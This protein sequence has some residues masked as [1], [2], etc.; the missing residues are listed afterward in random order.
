MVAIFIFDLLVTLKSTII[1]TKYKS[2]NI[3][4][5]C[6][7]MATTLYKIVKIDPTFKPCLSNEHINKWRAIIQSYILWNEPLCTMTALTSDRFW[8]N[9]ILYSCCYSC[10]N[11]FHMPFPTVFCKSLCQ[12]PKYYWLKQ[13]QFLYLHSQQWLKDQ[14][15][16]SQCH[17]AA[18]Q[19]FQTKM[20]F[21]LLKKV[22]E[23]A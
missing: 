5:W 4:I 8:Y 13:I 19:R 11:S 14:T 2:T 22:Q 17:A 15:R 7:F 1:N 20:G 12:N 23:A 21:L 16:S 3:Q 18:E 9:Y 10:E 6:I